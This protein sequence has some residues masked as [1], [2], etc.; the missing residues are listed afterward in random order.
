MDILN[1]RLRE[2]RNWRDIASRRLDPYNQELALRACKSMET[3][4]RKEI[5]EEKRKE[6]GDFLNQVKAWFLNRGM[7]HCMVTV[8][9]AALLLYLNSFR[10]V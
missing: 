10:R 9:V 8:V 3:S 6:R 7:E 2:V 4:I 5:L 1:M